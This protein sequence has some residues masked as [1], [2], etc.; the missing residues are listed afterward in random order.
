MIPL[1]HVAPDSPRYPL[2]L[3]F[4][5][6]TDGADQVDFDEFFEWYADNKDKKNPF[7][8]IT[9]GLKGFFANAAGL[10]EGFLSFC[11]NHSQLY[12]ESL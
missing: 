6:A 7:G 4:N 2:L 5:D 11:L 3:F 12:G 10:D 1:I 9:G 8:D